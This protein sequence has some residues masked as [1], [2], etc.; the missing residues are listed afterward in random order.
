MTSPALNP[1]VQNIQRSRKCFRS[2]CTSIL[3]FSAGRFGLWSS[4]RRWATPDVHKTARESPPQLAVFSLNPKCKCLRPLTNLTPSDIGLNTFTLY[5]GLVQGQS[6][7]LAGKTQFA[8]KRRKRICSSGPKT[9]IVQAL[10]PLVFLL[11]RTFQFIEVSLSKRQIKTR[12]GNKILTFSPQLQ[13]VLPEQ[14]SVFF[15]CCR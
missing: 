13:T 9:V 5:A 11:R 7:T 1:T 6:R 10:S 3:F 14:S 8:K 2:L 12:G 4:V 15:A